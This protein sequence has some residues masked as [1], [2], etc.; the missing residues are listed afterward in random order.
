ME[1]EMMRLFREPVPGQRWVSCRQ[2][3]TW[4][5]PTDVYETDDHFVVKVEIAG[6]QGEDLSITLDGKRLTIA[7]VRHDPAAKLA[8]QQ[9]EIAYG[10]FESHVHLPRAVDSEQIEATYRDGFLLVCLPKARARQVPI[11]SH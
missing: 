11:I 7:G 8:Y 1:A 5:P 9:M 4:C 6:M 2:A 3:Q 10:Q